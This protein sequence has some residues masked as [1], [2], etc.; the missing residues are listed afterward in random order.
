M[1][2][3]KNLDDDIPRLNVAGKTILGTGPEWYAVERLGG[4]F[5]IPYFGFVRPDPSKQD[6]VIVNARPENGTERQLQGFS[7][8]AEIGTVFPRVFGSKLTDNDYRLVV[9]RSSLLKA[10]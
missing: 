9:Y 3:Y 2:E 5:E 6:Y 1:R 10:Y 8:V 7:K 4:H